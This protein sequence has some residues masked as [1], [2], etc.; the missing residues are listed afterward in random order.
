M[1]YRDKLPPKPLVQFYA[2]APVHILS[3]VDKGGMRGGKVYLAAYALGCGATG[4][5]FLDDEVTEFFLPHA[6]GKSV[7]FLMAVG[8]PA[9]RYAVS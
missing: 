3:A 6:A 9:R 7:M 8:R 4:L 1:G 2:A 5:T